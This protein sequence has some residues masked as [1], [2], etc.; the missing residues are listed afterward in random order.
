[1]LLYSPLVILLQD[2]TISSK[3]KKKDSGGNANRE[4]FAVVINWMWNHHKDQF[5]KFLNAGLFEE[6]TCF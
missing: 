5:L 1:M 3:G 2:S 6:Y 4:G